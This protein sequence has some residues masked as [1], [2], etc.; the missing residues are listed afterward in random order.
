MCAIACLCV[1]RSLCT[2]VVQLFVILVFPP[3]GGASIILRRLPA[4]TRG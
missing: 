2:P 4:E 1:F 3:A